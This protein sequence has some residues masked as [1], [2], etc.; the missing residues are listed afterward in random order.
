MQ[1]KN[2]AKKYSLAWWLDS[3]IPLPG[4]YRIGLD[5]IIGLI[6]GV[7]DAVGGGLSSF[8]LYQ[9]Y[10]Q[11]APKI[12]LAR[13]LINILIDAMLGAIPI[14]GDIFDF[15]W[16]ANQRNVALMNEYKQQPARTYRRA[17]GS[18]IIFLIGFVA[19]IVGF[20]YLMILLMRAVW[21][22]IGG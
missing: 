17:A 19:L 5:G 13:M 8:I 14:I 20:V 6:P 18:S 15:F 16:K 2:K 3:S 9:A 1:N 10:Q 7:G 22:A 12:I 4:G 11:G 21:Q